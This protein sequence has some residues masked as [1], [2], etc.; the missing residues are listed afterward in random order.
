MLLTDFMDRCEAY[1]EG[2]GSMVDQPFQS[3]LAEGAIRCYLTHDEVVGFAHQI[4]RGFL[5]PRDTHEDANIPGPGA[6]A[7]E[8]ALTT[9]MESE[10]VPALKGL[11]DIDTDSLPVIW[12]ADFLLGPKTKTGED[13]FVLSE[14]N[15]SAVF[16]FPEEAV[17]GVARAALRRMLSKYDGTG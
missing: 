15:V 13:T 3:R 2:S 9:K 10:W 8:K 1:F 6:R 14:I 5:P 17:R 7:N 16:P 11:L 12:D 4:P